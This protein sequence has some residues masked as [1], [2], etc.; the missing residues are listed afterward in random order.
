MN[1]FEV[2][3]FNIETRDGKDCLSKF[4]NSTNQDTELEASFDTLEEAKA[5]YETLTTGV[6]YMSGYYLH[7]CKMIEENEYDED[8]EWVNGG[9]WIV[10]ETPNID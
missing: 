3:T 10:I 8:G 7:R 1:K 6:F 2:R 4:F 9:D 5:F